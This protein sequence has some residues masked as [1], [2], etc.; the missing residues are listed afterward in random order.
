MTST[1]TLRGT[2][3]RA[4][5]LDQLVAVVLADGFRHL[6]LDEIARRL[7]C[8]KSTLYGIAAS[9]EQL[10]VAAVRRFFQRA[11]LAVESRA[12]GPTDHRRQLG[13]YLLAVSEQLGPA[14]AAFFADM[15][16]FAPTREIYQRNTQLAA[17]RVRQL[18]SGGVRAG[19]IRPVHAA[20][21]GAAVTQVMGAIHR[22]EIATATGLDDAAAY[23]ELAALVTAG[24]APPVR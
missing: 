24:V 8:S 6:T 9:K 2:A 15:S 21:V 18:V 3:R 10:V 20:F 13:E 1:G 22:G 11:T 23:R 4:E 14:S 5:V 17:G 19:T 12:A 16:A 7:H